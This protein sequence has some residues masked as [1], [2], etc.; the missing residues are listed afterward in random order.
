MNASDADIA[1]I[2]HVIQLAVAPVFLISGIGALLGVVVTRLNRVIDRSR[3]VEASWK[4]LDAAARTD[5]RDEL[6]VLAKRA[7]LASGAINACAAAALLVCIVIATLFIDAF[8]G[9][10]LRWIV[11]LQFI[12]SMFVLVFGLICLMREV[13]LATHTL[14]I[15]PPA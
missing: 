9:T 3:V 13:Y 2:A 10:R 12:L 8:F 11:G 1:L 4:Q 14:R 6:T 5:A 15:G 7:R